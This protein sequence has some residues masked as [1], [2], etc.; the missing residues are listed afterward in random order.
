M[1]W[2]PD[3][4]N[5][6]LQSTEKLVVGNDPRDANVANSPT[7]QSGFVSHLIAKWGL[8]AATGMQYYILD[9]EPSIWWATHR[10]VAPLGQT[11]DVSDRKSVV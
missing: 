10:D 7:Y 3:A 5:G 11:M 2:Y 4:G 6:V 9:N 8:S 1:N